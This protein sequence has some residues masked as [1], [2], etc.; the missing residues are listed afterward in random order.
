M[1]KSIGQLCNLDCKYCI[2][3]EKDK[4]FSGAQSRRMATEVL[5]SYIRQSIAAQPAQEVMFAW[6]RAHPAQR[7]FF[8]TVVELEKKYSGG[9]NIQNAIQTKGVLIDDE[10]G[11]SENVF[12]VGV[13]RWPAGAA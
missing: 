5:E 4:L 11:L 8:R 9:K 2:Y 1:T 6:G 7:A 13:H 10:W 12:L 3:L